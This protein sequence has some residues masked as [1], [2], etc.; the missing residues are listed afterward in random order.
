MKLYT[1]SVNPNKAE[2]T[3]QSLVPKYEDCEHSR[4]IRRIYDFGGETPT[5]VNCIER[6]FGK[7]NRGECLGQC[8][9]A[10]KAYGI[11]GNGNN[12]NE[13]KQ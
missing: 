9:L 10:G 13:A 2:A 7:L 5:F 6:K 3:R 8:V 4:P 1:V 11:N 12:K